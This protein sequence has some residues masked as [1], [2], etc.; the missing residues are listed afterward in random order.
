MV[1]DEIKMS[2]ILSGGGGGGFGGGQYVAYYLKFR[3][4]KDSPLPPRGSPLWTGE[5]EV[6]KQVD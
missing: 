3:P 1:T 6:F 2:Q 5:N 4:G